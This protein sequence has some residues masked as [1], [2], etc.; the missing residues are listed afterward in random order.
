M[1]PARSHVWPTHS[2]L[3]KDMD[4]DIR[5]LVG[6]ARQGDRA[7]FG[8]L[9]NEYFAPIYRFVF[10][11]I[12]HK[13]TAEDLTQAVFTKALSAIANFSDTGAPVLSWLYTIARNHCIDYYKKKRDV[14]VG[15]QEGFWHEIADQ[16]A[17][18]AENLEMREKREIIVRVM[19]VLSDDQR[20]LVI[21]RFIEEKSYAE[22][23]EI[24]GKSE[25]SLR[26]MNYRAMK[27][28]REEL[29]KMKYDL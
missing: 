26:A 8:E 15:D 17:G 9:Y 16:V 10:F 24:L 18:P 23:A 27:I 28:L 29:G 2:F 25:E 22:I 3:N 1:L 21:L 7:A 20:E 12:K 19:G 11:K 5:V 14:T 4:N 13:E 6:K